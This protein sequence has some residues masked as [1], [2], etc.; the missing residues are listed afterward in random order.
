M[1]FAI[2]QLLVIQIVLPA[3]FIYEL[4]RAKVKNRL[5]WIII[6]LF[7]I[8]FAIWL[9]LSGRWDWTG[10]YFKYIWL[11]LLI[12]AIYFSWQKTKDL[13]FRTTLKTGQKFSRGIYIFLL[14][15]FG[16]YNLNIFSGYTTNDDAVDLAFPLQE[17]T[18]YIGHG[19]SSTQLN[20]HNTYEP[21]AYAVDIVALNNFGFRAN[22]LYP[23]DLEKYEIYS[24]TLY[25]P[26]SGEVVE[27]GDGRPDMTPPEMD[28]ENPFGN[29]VGIGCKETKADVYIAHMQ[30]NSVAVDKGDTIQEG[31]PIGAVGNS[32]NTS[33]PHLH[34]HAEKDSVGV[35]ITFDG[36]FLTRNDLIRSH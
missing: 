29:Y 17:G 24:H 25:A 33:E 6:L 13:P 21:Q 20:Y 34:I 9:F 15:V 35:P 8:T 30:E 5:D 32:G 16:L 23:K 22:G 19:G 1:T 4:W 12:P 14:L 31:Q 10:Y 36:K 11:I 2:I 28:S 7:T 26:C 3:Y 18:Y 27:S